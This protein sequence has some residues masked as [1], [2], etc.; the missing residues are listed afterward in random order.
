MA[1]YMLVRHKVRDFAEWKR[2]YDAHL[3]W[4]TE[5]GLAE[6]YVLHGADDANEIVL[7]FQLEDLERGKAFAASDDLREKMKKAGVVDKPDIQF[8]SA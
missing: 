2:V 1:S 6:R 4:R 5:A 8:L 7:F 3:P